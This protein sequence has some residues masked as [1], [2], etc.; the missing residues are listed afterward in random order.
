MYYHKFVV[1]ESG[2]DNDPFVIIASKEPDSE[3]AEVLN[4]LRDFLDK[5]GRMDLLAKMQHLAT[6]SIET[7][8]IHSNI[9]KR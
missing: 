1:D 4:T 3:S 2:L 6:P 7:G 9:D 8:V 5:Q